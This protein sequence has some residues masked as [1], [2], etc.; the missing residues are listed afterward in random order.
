MRQL[1]TLVKL[2]GEH[3]SETEKNQTKTKICCFCLNLDHKD[4][5]RSVAI[6]MKLYNFIYKGG[7]FKLS[8]RVCGLG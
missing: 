8:K 1:N 5:G 7:S 4:I 2:N 3:I 6:A